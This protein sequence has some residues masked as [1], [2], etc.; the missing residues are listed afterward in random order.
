MIPLPDSDPF[1]LGEHAF[2][3]GDVDKKLLSNLNY[4][5][6]PAKIIKSN[7]DD[8]SIFD[9][10]SIVH[11]LNLTQYIILAILLIICLIQIGFFINNFI[12][13]RRIQKLH[14][15][16]HFSHSRS[17]SGQKIEKPEDMV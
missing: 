8:N 2:Y 3:E 9:I 13:H 5:F 11:H 10:S 17:D 7:P 1:L 15:S 6:D 16:S 14:Q 4:Q 12:R